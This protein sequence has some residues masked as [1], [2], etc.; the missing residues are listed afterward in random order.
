M[1]KVCQQQSGELHISLVLALVMSFWM[2]YLVL[3]FPL[4]MIR[5]NIYFIKKR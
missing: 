4:S 2:R 5:V 3:Q 1:G